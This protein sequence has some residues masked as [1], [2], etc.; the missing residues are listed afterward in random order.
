MGTAAYIAI[1]V[2]LVFVS[3]QLQGCS[4]GGDSAAVM[5]GDCCTNCAGRAYCS[6]QSGQCHDEKP[7]DKDYYH[8]CGG[9]AFDDA[10]GSAGGDDCCNHC[11]GYAHCSPQSG[12][13]HHEKPWDKDYYH[14]CGG[15]GSDDASGSDGG[16]CC[17][18]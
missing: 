5:S 14:D 11:A 16:H 3:F 6:P 10:S 7:W 17:S 18:Q 8:D 2:F 13:C 1:F 15:S 12:Q 9:S 4:N